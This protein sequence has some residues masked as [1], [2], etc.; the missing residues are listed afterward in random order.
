MTK[1]YLE[2][3]KSGAISHED[4]MHA[5]PMRA[6]GRQTVESVLRPDPLPIQEAFGFGM[7]DGLAVRF[8]HWYGAGAA[9]EVFQHYA[10]VCERQGDKADEA[11]AC[12]L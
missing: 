7:L 5:D 3:V 1:S 10:A 9:A 8:V 2:Y 11:K 4:A 12:G 6:N